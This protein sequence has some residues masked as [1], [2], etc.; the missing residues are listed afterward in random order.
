MYHGKRLYVAVLFLSVLF[1]FSNFVYAAKSV[2]VIADT[3]ISKVFAYEVSGTN[4]IYQTQYFC[5]L[6]PNVGPNTD[7]GA[8]AVAID[9]SGFGNFLFFSFETSDEIELVNAKTMQYIDKVIAPGASDLAGI[10]MDKGKS[11]LYAVDR[12]TK[13]LYSWSWDPAIRKL[14]PDFNEPYYI[15]LE[16]ISNQSGEGAIGIALDEENG[17]L[18]VADNT[19]TI[20]YYNTTTWAKE[21]EIN[22]SCN[23]IGVAI[24]VQ[25]QFLYYGS[26]GYYGQGD[27]NLYKYDLS[28]Q[29]ESSVCLCSNC[30]NCSSSCCPDASVAGIAV[31]QSTSL[32]YITTLGVNGDVTNYPDP[33]QDRI[34]VYNS[35]L[36]RL[37]FSEDIGNPAGVAVAANVGYKE[38]LFKITKDNNNPAY[39]CANP[40]DLITFNIHYDANTHPDTNAFVIDYLPRELD[41]VSSNPI[42][43]YNSTY[44]T[45][46]WNLPN[47]NGS[48]SGTVHITTTVNTRNVPCGKITNTA[49]LE[50]DKYYSVA[51]RDVNVC[52]WTNIVFVNEH[53]AGGDGSGTS[54]ENAYSNLQMALGGAQLMSCGS[55][56]WVAAGNYKPTNIPDNAEASFELVEGVHLYGHF[57]GNETSL[58]ARDL[59]DVNSETILDGL[60]D[61]VHRVNSVINGRSIANSVTI[62]GFTIQKAGSSLYN[63]G[64]Y[65]YDCDV[66]V[67]NCKISE[68]EVGI[69]ADSSSNLTVANTIF[70]NNSEGLYVYESSLILKNNNI[71]YNQGDGVYLEDSR[72][73][74]IIN[75]W[76]YNNGDP[77]SLWGSGIYYYSG[78]TYVPVF[79]NNTICNNRYCG[80]LAES[81]P[82]PII[83]NC[84]I[85]GNARDFSDGNAFNVNYCCLQAYHSGTKNIYG[86]ANDP[87][88]VNPNPPYDL[89]IKANSPCKDTGDPAGNYDGETDI[90]GEGRLNGVV[91][92]G[93]DEYYYHSAA[94]FDKSGTVDFYDYAYLAKAW[95]S[96]PINNN[97]NSICDLKVDVDNAINAGDLKLFCD[98]WLKSSGIAQGQDEGG[99]E[100]MGEEGEEF[101]LTF[102]SLVRTAE[103]SA[104]AVAAGGDAEA[105]LEWTDA[106]EL[107][108]EMAGLS[109]E[110]YDTFRQALEADLLGTLDSAADQ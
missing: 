62:D 101:S 28:A 15:E 16:G 105:I 71:S 89:H 18:Y 72:E 94:D 66:I 21:G 51:L 61:S 45:V 46:K 97:W 19:D 34:M 55:Q 85:R 69:Y 23:A 81:G 10:A 6:D 86:D 56:I 5:R 38:P 17:F 40:D 83:R 64:I 44:H 1:V 8:V 31:D 74:T 33:P 58:D 104:Q 103:L 57:A 96:T 39:N 12:F 108:A 87:C 14:T 82:D 77:Y 106:I 63:G 9:E 70:S 42:A 30:S 100:P 73:T 43:D 25:N 27:P 20:K 37:W 80:I 79:R 107:E 65:L 35:S 52:N 92:I 47:F 99:E 2:Y 13:N 3:E 48:S 22:V 102:N 110:G 109:S 7:A 60:I 76:I 26:I 41:Y 98:D 49:C 68:N 90:D 88:F 78:N 54:W 95:L 24:D 75:N 4:L 11:K 29:N 59:A 93:A 36:Q 67:Q 53:V 32:V 84:I 50:S 91:D